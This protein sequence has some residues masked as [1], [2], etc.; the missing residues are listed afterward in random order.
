MTPINQSR[1]VFRAMT[2][3]DVPTIVA[4]E[5]ECFPTPWTE[6][7]FVN[8]LTN[9]HFARYMVM[10]YEDHVIG[11]AGMWTIM[12]EAHVTNV[13]V[14][15]AYRGQG[16]GERLMK[17]LQRT[18]LLFGARRMT[19]E[20]RVSNEVA[21]RLYAK[22]GFEPSGIRPGYYS[23]NMEDAL[24]MWAELPESIEVEYSYDEERN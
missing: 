23:D 6:E 8:E 3:D 18:A 15:E 5:Q 21:K 12:D 22:L 14:R 11:Y 10:D 17:E 16:L 19:L 9:N 2:M 13:A 4:I 24:I 1:L 20:V 7:A